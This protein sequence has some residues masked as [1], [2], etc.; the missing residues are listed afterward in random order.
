MKIVLVSR[1]YPPLIGGAEKVFSYLARALAA[2]GA[3]VTVLTARPTEP[4]KHAPETE[5]LV[6]GEGRL[7]VVRIAS[8]RWHFVGTWLYMRRLSRRLATHA[9]DIAYVSM[10]KHDAWV[11]VTAGGIR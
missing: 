10:L 2:E 1:R 5:S 7:T 11:T 4:G 6:V 3:E 8:S 9:L